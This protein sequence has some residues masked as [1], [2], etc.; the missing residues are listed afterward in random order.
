MSKTEKSAVYNILAFNFEGEKTAE[1]TVKEIKES[2]ALD[3]QAIVAEA[4]VAVDDKGKPHIHEPG[5]GLLG[6]TAG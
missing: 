3:G 2:G 6:G 5:H 4:I 1:E